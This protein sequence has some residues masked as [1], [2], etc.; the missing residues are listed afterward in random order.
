MARKYTIE[1]VKKIFEDNNCKLLSKS[2]RNNQTKVEYRCECGNISEIRLGSFLQGSRCKKCG[3]RERAKKRRHSYEEVKGVFKDNNCELLS[4]NYKNGNE[5]LDYICSCGFLAKIRFYNFLRGSRCKKCAN[6]KLAKERTLLYEEVKDIFESN[7]CKLLSKNYK[8]SGELLD[9]ICS[10]GSRSKIR[11]NNFSQGQRCKKCG[12]KKLAE[13]KRFSCEKVKDIFESNNC[14]LLSK[15]YKNSGE[16]LDYRCSCGSLAKVSLDRFSRGQRCKRC[17]IEKK[18]G[19]NH[20]NYNPNLTDE[21]RIIKR[22][23]PAYKKWRKNVYTRDKGICRKCERRKKKINAHHIEGYAENR[24]LR[25]FVPNG[26][27]WCRDCHIEFHKI[28][29]NKNNNRKQYNKFMKI[30]S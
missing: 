2:Y 6:K 25:T 12:I 17:G 21:D 11:L 23:Y 27:T 28:Y 4:E 10:C 3:I 13:E 29:G 5:L 15:N 22:S 9:Y 19:K 8:N 16:L 7:N 14:K 18:S 26:V 1:Q 24:E 20:F 30:A